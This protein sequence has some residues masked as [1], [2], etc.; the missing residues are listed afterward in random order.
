MSRNIVLISPQGISDSGGVER[1][2]L[3]AAR[4]LA[5]RGYHVKIL[6]RKYLAGT[7]IGTAFARCL[8]GRMAFFWQSVLLSHLA[9]RYRKKGARIISNGYAAFLTT[10]DLLFCHGSMHGFR[11]AKAASGGTAHAW[12]LGIFG[13]EE[14]MEMVAGLKARKIIAVSPDAAREWK[15][16]YRVS[17]AKLNILPNPVDT[18]HFVP[19][20]NDSGPPPNPKEHIRI[21][22]VGRLEWRKGIDRVNALA[23]YCSEHS[24]KARIVLAAPGQS[25]TELFRGLENVL[26]RRHVSYAQLPALYTGCDVF[27][28]PS[29]YEGFEMVTLEA[30]SCGIPVVGTPVGAIAYLASRGFPGVYLVDPENP[31][32]VYA[33]L[34]IAAQEWKSPIQKQTLHKAVEQ[35][36]AL[37]QWSRQFLILAGAID[38]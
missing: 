12:K 2:M 21:L 8:S 32:Q 16:H 5:E 4:A 29:R 24:K 14:I 27:Y 26:I 3:Y 18:A 17:A 34:S 11:I 20:N 1:V 23:R 25:G 30:L 28:F 38:V 33:T 19:A 10:A 7:S 36:F 9:G 35:A 6:D 15:R 31:E 37:S 22:F 13:L